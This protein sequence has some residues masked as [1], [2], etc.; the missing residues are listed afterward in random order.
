MS[1][2][3]YFTRCLAGL[4]LVVI[5]GCAATVP[6]TSDSLDFKG[7]SFTPPFDKANLYIIRGGSL[8]ARGILFQVIVDG[9]VQ[10]A[11]AQGTYFLL[12]ISPGNHTVSV[13]SEESA[14]SMTFTAT[15]G[16]NFFI[17]IKSQAGWLSSSVSVEKLEEEEGRSLVVESKRAQ[18]FTT[19]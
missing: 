19:D 9:K 14:D 3:A 10:G 8:L 5:S 7:K 12:P 6:L 17:K 11:I 15:A 1:R 13:T 18:H 2:S 16:N 4:A